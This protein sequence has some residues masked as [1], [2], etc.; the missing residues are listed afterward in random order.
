MPF[1]KKQQDMLAKSQSHGVWGVYHSTTWSLSF[2]PRPIHAQRVLRPTFFSF[3]EPLF[4]SLRHSH[5]LWLVVAFSRMS[6][7]PMCLPLCFYPVVTVLHNQPRAGEEAFDEE[8]RFRICAPPGD[9]M[10][11]YVRVSLKVFLLLRLCD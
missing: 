2:V 4:F 11:I 3:I 8:D 5:F 7:L 6:C 9:N 10:Y 1:N